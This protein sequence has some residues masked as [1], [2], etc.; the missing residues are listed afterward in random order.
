M[1]IPKNARTETI[2]DRILELIF[3]VNLVGTLGGVF[4]PVSCQAVAAWTTRELFFEIIVTISTKASV[5]IINSW[6]VSLFKLPAGIFAL[7]HTTKYN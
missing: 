6:F 2:T 5:L 4:S 7:H 1:L 3:I